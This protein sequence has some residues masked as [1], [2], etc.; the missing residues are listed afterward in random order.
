MSNHT[1]P[2]LDILARLNNIERRQIRM[3]TRFCKFLAL[4]GV[5]SDGAR[6]EGPSKVPSLSPIQPPSSENQS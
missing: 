5:S 6:V 2:V 3:E 4:V 1:N